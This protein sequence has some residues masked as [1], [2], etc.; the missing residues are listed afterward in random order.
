MR[1]WEKGVITQNSILCR[2]SL[3]MKKTVK[4]RQFSDFISP[5]NIKKQAKPFTHVGGLEVDTVL[6]S[7]K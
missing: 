2:N 7:K 4:Y 3:K 6:N 5:Q 1:R